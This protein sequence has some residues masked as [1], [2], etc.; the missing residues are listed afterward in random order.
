MY[1]IYKN[2]ITN[3]ICDVCHSVFLTQYNYI[4]SYCYGGYI[5]Y[6]FIQH[7]TTNLNSLD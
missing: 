2:T 6:K 7:L 5:M 3:L 4:K 1:V